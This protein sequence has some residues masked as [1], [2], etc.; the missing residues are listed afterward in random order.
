M[1]VSGD[2]VELANVQEFGELIEM[3]HR[4]VAAVLAEK[5]YILAEIH[6]L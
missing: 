6:V 4:L 3:E 1:V 5:G 2:L